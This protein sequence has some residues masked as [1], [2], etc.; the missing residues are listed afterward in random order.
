MGSIEIGLLQVSPSESSTLPIHLAQVGFFQVGFTE[1]SFLQMCP[2]EECSL[3]VGPGEVGFLEM[4]FVQGHFFQVC[5]DEF[6]LLQVRLA[7][8]GSREKNC[9]GSALFFGSLIPLFAGEA[10]EQTRQWKG[11][12][13][14]ITQVRGPQIQAL[15]IPLLVA[16]RSGI[17]FTF[18]CYQEPLDIGCIAC[19]FFGAVVISSG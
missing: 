8:I 18:E 6:S 17:T 11:M 1:V 3:Q 2:G 15:A 13:V 4:R 7:Q 10:A 14:C 9:R 19:D 12:Q 5:P 16:G